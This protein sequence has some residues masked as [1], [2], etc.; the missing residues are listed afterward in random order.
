[1]Y[2]KKHLFKVIGLI[3]FTIFFCQSSVQALENQ[4]LDKTELESFG[5]T[6]YEYIN[7]NLLI[8]PIKRIIE[9]VSINLIFDKQKKQEYLLQLYEKRFIELLYIINNKKEGFLTFTADRYN[10]FVGTLKKEDIRS[11]SFKSQ[12]EVKIK[13]L[14]RLRDIYPANSENWSKLQQAIDTTKSLI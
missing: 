5:F 13:F 8:Y 6:E 2:I 1:M 11:V 9:S 12:I 3:I 10:S 7:P 14:E 4:Y